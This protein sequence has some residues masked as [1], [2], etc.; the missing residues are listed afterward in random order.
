MKIIRFSKL[1]G[2][3]VET[4]SGNDLG[5]LRDIELDEYFLHCKNILVSPTGLVK[6]IINEDLIIPIED[7]IEINDNKIIVSDS[8]VKEKGSKVIIEKMSKTP[9][10]QALNS[11]N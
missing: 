1:K 4:K 2:R 7:I 11:E 10:I 3:N 6:K 9:S 8:I 5:V